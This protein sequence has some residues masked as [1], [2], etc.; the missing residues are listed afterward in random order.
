MSDRFIIDAPSDLVTSSSRVGACQLI[1]QKITGVV[2]AH[3]IELGIHLPM[4][5][6]CSLLWREQRAERHQDR[7]RLLDKF[8]HSHNNE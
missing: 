4:S 1:P 6:L 7:I 3:G 8:R 5:C 2:D